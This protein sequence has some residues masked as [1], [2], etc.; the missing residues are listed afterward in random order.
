MIGKSLSMCVKE[1]MEGKV[2]ADDVTLVVAGTFAK[3]KT[4]WEMLLEKYSETYWKANPE[5]G[6]QIANELLYTGRIIQP[7][8]MNKFPAIDCLEGN[9]YWLDNDHW[10][11]VFFQNCQNEL[12]EM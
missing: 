12:N 1:I 7:K 10:L 5:Y 8:A 2:D 11:E 9:V 6:K 3:G 4:S